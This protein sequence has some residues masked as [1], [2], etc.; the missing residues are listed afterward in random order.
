MRYAIAVALALLAVALGLSAMPALRP[1]GAQPDL[2]LVLAVCWALVWTPGEGVALAVLAGTLSDLPGPRPVGVSVLAALPALLLA[3]LGETAIAQAAFPAALVAVALGTLAQHLVQL[4]VYALMGE[5]APWGDALLRA[6]LPAAVM[7]LLWTP[8]VYA[9]L[10]L[11][12][13]LLG[14]RALGPRLGG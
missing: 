7:N 5:G 2:A 12:R 4:V 6:A 8:L 9:L 11:L 3:S 14:P 1:W 13:A 10:R